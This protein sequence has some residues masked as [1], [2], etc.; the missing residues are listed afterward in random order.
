MQKLLYY[1]P[2]E[3][4]NFAHLWITSK[5]AA[6]FSCCIPTRPCWLWGLLRLKQ[7]ER[8]FSEKTYCH[9]F[10]E[11][12]DPGPAGFGST[13]TR[14]RLVFLLGNCENSAL[15]SLSIP[16]RSMQQTL[17]TFWTGK[18]SIL[19]GTPK[20][21]FSLLQER[22]FYSSSPHCWIYFSILG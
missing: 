11:N 17:L 10:V 2:T 9:K 12:Y 21:L 6:S 5:R 19:I 22:F 3:E 8:F 13:R 7:A 15:F 18:W 4:Q 1:E 16:A 14:T 20:N